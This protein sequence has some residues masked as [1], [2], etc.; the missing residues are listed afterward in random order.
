MKEKLNTLGLVL[1]LI[2]FT[3]TS[4][5]NQYSPNFRQ[6]YGRAFT[7]PL[8]TGTCFIA[9]RFLNPGS[10]CYAKWIGAVYVETIRFNSHED[11]HA[12][13]YVNRNGDSD[14]Q[15]RSSTKFSE[16]DLIYS[17]D[18]DNSE[19]NNFILQKVAVSGF[20]NE[21][22]LWGDEKAS[23][24]LEIDHEF[25]GNFTLHEETKRGASSAI[26]VNHCP[27]KIVLYASDDQPEV[28][29]IAMYWELPI[30]SMTGRPVLPRSWNQYGAGRPGGGYFAESLSQSM[31]LV[32]GHLTDSQRIEYT[33]PLKLA[34]SSFKRKMIACDQDFVC[35]N[36]EGQL[37]VNTFTPDLKHTLDSIIGNFGAAD[38]DELAADIE[39]LNDRIN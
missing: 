5:A 35:A 27:H 18:V 6:H 29:E 34:I 39:Y 1:A 23:V 30:D 14:Q 16:N 12:A 13:E 22:A 9:G 36:S 11:P 37:V 38:L 17:L 4:N 15:R 24:G 19:Y 10:N 8:P 26:H 32:E 28:T 7:A 21:F 2:G 33:Q 25:V 20:T 31:S 3:L